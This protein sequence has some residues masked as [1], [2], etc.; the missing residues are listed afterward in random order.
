[1][2]HHFTIYQQAEE[3]KAPRLPPRRTSNCDDRQPQTEMWHAI[4][5]LYQFSETVFFNLNA[6]HLDTLFFQM[7]ESGG[8]FRRPG[9]CKEVVWVI[10]I[11]FTPNVPLAAISPRPRL[12]LSFSTP[13]DSW[14]RTKRKLSIRGCKDAPSGAVRSSQFVCLS[15]VCVSLTVPSLFL[16]LF[17]SG[18]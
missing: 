15:V 6:A 11:L 13:G 8:F 16:F 5:L 17:T 10:F 1:M 14:R 18:M 7:Y 12:Y 4:L 2:R 3:T 9:E